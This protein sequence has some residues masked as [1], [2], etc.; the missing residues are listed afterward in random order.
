MDLFEKMATYVRVIEAGSFSA[1]AKQSKITSGAV[2]RQIAAL[3][4]ELGVTLIARSTRS[5]AATAEGHRYYEQCLRVLREVAAAQS[6]GESRGV[7]GTVRVGAPVS[8]GLA[9]LMPHIA[10]LRAKHPALRVELHLEDRLLDTV[11]EGLDVLVRAGA[12]VPLTTGVIARRLTAFPFV[13]VAAPSYLRTHGEPVT[14][15][16]LVGHDALSCHMAAGPDIWVLSNEQ[17]EARVT[18]TETIVFRCSALQ[19]VRD[20]ALA[21]HGVALL[22]DWFVSSDLEQGS[23]RS[24]LPGWSTEHIPVN[25]IYRTTQRETPR[26]R[27]LVDH[28][29]EAL[30]EPRASALT[31]E[32]R[33]S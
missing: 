14:P 30:A 5:M 28:I 19:G 21:G 10:T 24:V 11:L 16:A 6:I 7:E 29:V 18:M 32:R 22:P 12:T 3:E 1:A 31:R 2:S 33:A 4:A 26:V 23:L 17:R 15:E 27:A 25:A 8:F 13:L 20:L 9:A